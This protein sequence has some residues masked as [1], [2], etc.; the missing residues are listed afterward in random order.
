VLS[1]LWLALFGLLTLLGGALL[2][3]GGLDASSPD[4]VA[5]NERGRKTIIVAVANE[6]LNQRRQAI[7]NTLPSL[8]VRCPVPWRTRASA[9][10][11]NPGDG[12]AASSPAVV[13][14]PC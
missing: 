7:V 5:G 12:P 13:P 3:S 2:F 11:P 9:R 6:A 1:P 8:N 14:H 4:A 10:W